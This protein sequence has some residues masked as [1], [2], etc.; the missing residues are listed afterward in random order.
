MAKE[1]KAFIQTSYRSKKSDAFIGM[2]FTSNSYLR[3]GI[4]ENGFYP[5]KA[6]LGKSKVASFHLPAFKAGFSYKFS[7]RHVVVLNANYLQRAPV[8]N[9]VFSNVRVS[10]DLVHDLKPQRM[11]GIDLKYTW[12]HPKFNATISGYYL[13][14]KDASKVSFYYADG[15][16]GL[17]NSASSAFVQEVLTSVD[18]QNTGLEIG[19]EV[20]L[21]MNFKLKAVAALGSSIYASNPQLYLTSNTLEGSLNLGKSF[22]KG[23]YATGGPQ[24]LFSFGFEYSSPKYWWFSTSLNYFDKSFV[25]VA[26]ITR[27][28]NFLLD[29]DGLPIHDIDTDLAKELLIQEPLEP[30]MNLNMVGGKSW[31]VKDLYIGFFASI[32]NL[33]NNLYKTGGFE[34]ARNANYLALKEDKLR[35]K[36][37]FGPKYWFSYGATFFT[38]LYVRL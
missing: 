34:Q 19:L 7:G 18:K 20:P 36:P 14:I 32:N 5:E 29:T 12:R 15:L 22:L 8:M 28:K 31:K 6:S 35:S 37:L 4:Y 9:Y 2:A 21:F 38:S 23:Y 33:T 25:A 16:T 26:P 10:N 30:Y 27:T 3:N 13:R 11:M 1:A 17:E 24:E